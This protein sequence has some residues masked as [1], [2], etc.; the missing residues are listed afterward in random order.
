MKWELRIN[1]QLNEGEINL[2]PQWEVVGGLFVTG[3]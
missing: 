2:P 1:E 3:G